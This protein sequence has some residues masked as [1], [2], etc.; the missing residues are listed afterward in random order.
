MLKNS[1]SGSHE[2]ITVESGQGIAGDLNYMSEE[3]QIRLRLG[4]RKD[5]KQL[6]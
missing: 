5:G 6:V 3:D 2:I 1:Q 4:H